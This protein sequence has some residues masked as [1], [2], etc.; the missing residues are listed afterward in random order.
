VRV[1][2]EGKRSSVAQ[3]DSSQGGRA[4]IPGLRPPEMEVGLL[5][6]PT[7]AVV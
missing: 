1:Q 2:P 3:T 7:G 4:N 5:P 6:A